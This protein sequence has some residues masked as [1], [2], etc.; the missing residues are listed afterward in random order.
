M[1]LR[2]APRSVVKPKASVQVKKPVAGV[3]LPFD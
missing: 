3:A 1:I 2:P